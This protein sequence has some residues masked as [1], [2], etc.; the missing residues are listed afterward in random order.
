MIYKSAKKS[1]IDYLGYW[2]RWSL[3]NSV[4]KEKKGFL[5]TFSMDD[6]EVIGIKGDLILNS[7]KPDGTIRKLT[8]V[9]QLNNLGLK[10][11]LI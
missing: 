11:K 8:D 2:A 10:Y 7:D 3:L 4:L 9:S 6:K 1:S 5:D